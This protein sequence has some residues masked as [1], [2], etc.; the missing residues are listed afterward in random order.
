MS[1][2]T[3]M[4]LHRVLTAAMA[5]VTAE[6]EVAKAQPAKAKAVAVAIQAAT[7]ARAAA[8]AGALLAVSGAAV[9]MAAT[10]R[11]L[12]QHTLAPQAHMQLPQVQQH[13]G[14]LAERVPST[15]Q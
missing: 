8:A 11:H 13:G 3:P 5:A 12:Q 1:G 15:G 14:L 6:V 10:M 7:A 9:A 2:Y 4:R